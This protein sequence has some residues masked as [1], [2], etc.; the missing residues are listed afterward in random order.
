MS[1]K[2]TI[3]DCD[4][5]SVKVELTTSDDRKFYVDLSSDGMRF[6]D[7]VNSAGS[8][9]GKPI[10]KSADDCL[11]WIALEG[12]KKAFTAR[13]SLQTGARIK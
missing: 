13:K 9:V 3:R 10:F 5:R 1:V 4:I 11:Q 7:K 6:Y 8:Y 2:L 12:E